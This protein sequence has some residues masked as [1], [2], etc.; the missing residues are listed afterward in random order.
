[1]TEQI[2]TSQLPLPPPFDL[3]LFDG[4]TQFGWLTHETISN[5]VVAW[6]V[7]TGVALSLAFVVLALFAAEDIA[8]S[9]AAV[10]LG[11]LLA[12]RFFTLLI[13]WPARLR[14]WSARS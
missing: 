10:G 7:V 13:G 8:G 5:D 2:V 6:P 3:N 9:F 4:D 1:M 12:I 14:V 11:T